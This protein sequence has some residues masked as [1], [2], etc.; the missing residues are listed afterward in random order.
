MPINSFENYPMSWKP[1]RPSKGQ[2]LYK[3]IAEQLEQDINNG[4]LLP[5][6]KLPPQRELAD[7]LDVNVSTISR[8]FKICEKKGLISGVTGS[9]T[10]VSYDARSNLF[11][12]SSNSK[13]TFIEMGTMNPDFTLE[14]MNTLFKHI[15]KEIDFKTIFQYGQRDGAKW[16]K[17]AIV[18][19]IYKAGLETTADSL[20]PASG[21]Q[22]AIVAILAGLFQHGDRIGVDPLTYPGIKTAAK[23]LGIQLIPIKQGNG[24]ISEEGLLYSCKNE[25]IK[26]LYIIPDYQNPTTH[27]MSK[28]GRKMIAN[29]ASKYNLIVIEDA[30]HSLLNEAHLNPVASYIPNQTIYITSLSKIIAPSLRL[31]YISTPKQYREALSDALYNINLS[32]SYF[33]TEIAYRMITSGEADKLINAR[34]KSARRRNK[35]INQYLSGYNLLGSEECIFRWLILPDGIMAEKFEIQALK[36]GV[37]VYASE[38]FA[39]GKE[40]PIS[41]IRIAVC[42]TESTEELKAGLTVLKKLL[43]EER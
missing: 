2:I 9:G 15:I 13:I 7:F 29:I 6:T 28:N 4:F 21:G 32:Q 31:A 22:N 37:Q 17:E 27:I 35:I 18:K 12:M 34:R 8:A 5:G 26:G 43:E 3:A 10:F 36:E 1:K 23:M 33:L 42:A 19:L 14:E 38:R 30:I 40:K 20:L 39:V 41:A 16:Q 25:N 11:L 24:E